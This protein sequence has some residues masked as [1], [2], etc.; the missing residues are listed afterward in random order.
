MSS[1]QILLAAAT[2]LEL[3]PLLDR[4]GI[5][6]EIFPGDLLEIDGSP[7]VLVTGVGQA[8]TAYH[9]GRLLAKRTFD[10]ILNA[11]ICGAFDPKLALAS[12]VIVVSETFADLGA[13]RESGN[14][15]LFTMGFLNPDRIPFKNGELTTP[16]PSLKSL[17]SLPRVRSITVN[18]VINRV[19][20]FDDMVTR[21]HPDVVNMEGAAV[22]FA[23]LSEK[24]E[25]I[26]VRTVSD[27]VNPRRPSQWNIP[28]AVQRLDEI[29][30]A[31]L[32]ESR[33]S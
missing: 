5:R 11:G 32:A 27:H 10:L 14:V 18:R 12:G 6:R 9:M 33:N 1:K 4:F 30:A 19:E 31:V 8:L 17:E 2:A 3:R 21:Y 25:L 23:A 20:S 16:Q 29:L 15:D 28:D 22:F 24:I 7:S 13:E 26:S